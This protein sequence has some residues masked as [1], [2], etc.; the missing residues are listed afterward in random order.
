M[1]AEILVE[2]DLSDRECLE[3]DAKIGDITLGLI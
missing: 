1:N 2:P 3:S